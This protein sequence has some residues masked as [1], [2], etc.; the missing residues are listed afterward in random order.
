MLRVVRKKMIILTQELFVSLFIFFLFTKGNRSGNYRTKQTTPLASSLPCVTNAPSTS[1]ALA[2][3]SRPVSA[4]ST[5]HP[6]LHCH[7]GWLRAY[8]WEKST[9]FSAFLPSQDIFI[10][11]GVFA[12]SPCPKCPAFGCPSFAFRAPFE[13]GVRSPP[14]KPN[15]SVSAIKT[16]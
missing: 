15:S 14:A 10:P 12:G 1:P 5:L 16:T 3:S 6:F 4:L 7:C 2:W 8:C 13:N 11:P 9:K